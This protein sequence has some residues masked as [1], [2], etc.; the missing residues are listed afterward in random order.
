MLS[1]D[2]QRW[3]DRIVG[4]P[5]CWLLT[6]W[7]RLPGASPPAAEVRRVLV[8]ALSEMGALVLARPMFERL[9][10]RYPGASLFVLGFE[11]SQEALDLIDVVPRDRVVCIRSHSLGVFLTDSVQAVRRLRALS[12]DVV[13]DLELFAR[14]SAIFSALS[15]AP[16][17]VGFERHGQEGLYRGGFIN[18]PVLYNPHQHIADQFVTLVEAIDSA[19]V[20]R[21]KRLVV[22][23]VRSVERL[24][25]RPGELDAARRALFSQFPE[26]ES[27][28]LVFMGPGGGLMPLR[29]WPITHYMAVAR[30]LVER[31]FA[32]GVVGLSED[33][34]LAQVLRASC[35]EGTC[36][37]LT[38][39]T[40]SV[41]E[42]TVLFHLG[43]LLITSDG[44]PA[45][46]ASLAPIPAIVL[47]GPET[48]VL[49][50]SLSP[51]AV[52][53]HKPLSCSPCVSAYNHR[54]SPCDGDNVCLKSITP[55]EVLTASYRIL[56][57]ST[58]A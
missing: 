1:V 57:V 2:R 5:L 17:R 42:L 23:R 28:P 47:Y 21:G 3:V 29:A 27:R 32:I 8:I 50:G 44:G 15:G 52:N 16:L 22:P 51:D 9:R 26:L 39:Y 36:A 13:I 19:A 10:E 54:R 35:P 55:A 33:R 30:A 53:L 6:L 20:P 38:G 31:G 49:Y 43:A 4:P 11:R 18:R 45:H 24:S 12:I 46:F 37:D 41:R 48:P 40:R 7:H 34:G 14:A 58:P 56:G 25:L